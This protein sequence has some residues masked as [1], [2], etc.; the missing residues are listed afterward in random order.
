M[1]EETKKGVGVNAR[2]QRLRDRKPREMLK[3][4]V[5]AVRAGESWGREK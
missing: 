2:E 4:E 1:G 3:P 5:A